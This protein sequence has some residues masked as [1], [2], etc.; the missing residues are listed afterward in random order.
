MIVNNLK[1]LVKVSKQRLLN[2]CSTSLTQETI[3]GLLNYK[4]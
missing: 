2:I 1:K 4:L 3:V